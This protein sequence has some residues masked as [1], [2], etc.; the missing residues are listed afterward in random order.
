MI[1]EDGADEYASSPSAVSPAG[2]ALLHGADQ[3]AGLGPTF[4]ATSP[5]QARDRRGAL[6]R[7]AGHPN[8]EVPF[9][10]TAASELPTGSTPPEEPQDQP[11]DA[12]SLTQQLHNA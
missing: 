8:S 10:P 3:G 6:G 9:P 11:L 2:E 7:R 4:C 1:V 5:H 12:A